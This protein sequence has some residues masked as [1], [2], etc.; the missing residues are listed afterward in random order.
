MP[1]NSS[2]FSPAFSHGSAILLFSGKNA[3]GELARI[4]DNKNDRVRSR[5]IH[6]FDREMLK[7]N[8]IFLSNEVGSVGA[9]YL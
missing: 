3:E 5:K 2:P 9:A 1:R 4:K 7:G 6:T 8:F